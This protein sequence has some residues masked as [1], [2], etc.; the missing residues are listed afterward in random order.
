ML[1][2]QTSQSD[3]IADA[4]RRSPVGDGHEH[5]RVSDIGPPH[6]HRVLAAVLVQEEDPVLAPRLA[7]AGEHVLVTGQGMERVGY[8]NGPAPAI[9]MGCS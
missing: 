4:E 2:D 5:I 1:V 3:E 7:E 8:P 6:G 9:V